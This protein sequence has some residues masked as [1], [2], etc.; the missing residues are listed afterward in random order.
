[1]GQLLSHWSPITW[2]QMLA[3]ASPF[4][5]L[6]RESA[7]KT[8]AFLSL[9]FGHVAHNLGTQFVG[10]KRRTFLLLLSGAEQGV[11]SGLEPWI[12]QPLRCCVPPNRRPLPP[13]IYPQ[14]RPS[15]PTWSEWLSSSQQTPAHT[16]PPANRESPPAFPTPL[17]LSSTSTPLPLP[18]G[19]PAVLALFQV[20]CCSRLPLFA[21]R[22]LQ[23]LF[24]SL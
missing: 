19:P 6:L 16:H 4:S 7:P 20:L 13:S 8:C 23:G 9:Y 24:P 14:S 3:P 10:G 15:P 1:M 17:P 12:I 2:V 11:G 5:E 22:P 21:S 18:P